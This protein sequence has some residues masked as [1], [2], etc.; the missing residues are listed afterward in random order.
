MHMLPEMDYI[1]NELLP[2][3]RERKHIQDEKARRQVMQWRGVPGVASVL[4]SAPYED[5]PEI[6]NLPWYNLE[7]VHYDVEKMF[8]CGLRDTLFPAFSLGEAVPSMRANVGCGCLNT[9][10][11]GLK[12]TFF[13]DK[14]PWLLEHKTIDEMMEYTKDDITDSEEFSF[15]LECMR[16]MKEKLEGTGIEVYP[17]DI[18]GPIDMAH[19]WLGNEFFYDLYD[20]PEKMEHV[21]QLAVD[22]IEYAFG[23]FMEIIKP[24]DHVCHYNNL[25]MPVET[26]LKLSEDTSTLISKEHI[27]RFMVP[28]S[29]KILS[30]IGGGYLHYCG[31]NQHL[32]PVCE[33][34][35]GSYGLNFGNPERHDILNE[36]LPALARNGKQLVMYGISTGDLEK[37]L[38][39]SLAD[40]GSFHIL[41]VISCPVGKQE[42]FLDQRDLI[43]EKLLK[44]R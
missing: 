5:V 14:M 10:I 38:R 43:V 33:T 1:E 36:V 28:Y 15:G 26:P 3:L 34:F 39:A 37:Y 9:L 24:V 8:V 12:Q 44:E 22:C 42:Q 20:E 2:K 35:K 17:M 32:L 31:D 21:L 19:L 29:E 4:L 18:Q 27:E 25:A 30:R 7:E 23:R 16:F 41:P 11:G 40:D 13:P 6:K